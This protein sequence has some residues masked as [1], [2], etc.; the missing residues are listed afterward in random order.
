M[1]SAVDAGEASDA[2]EGIEKGVQSL[3]VAF[4]E[5]PAMAV[6][7]VLFQRV[8]QLSECGLELARHFQ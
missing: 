7:G 8:Q 4:Q 5:D 3:I 1:R 6:T 2:L